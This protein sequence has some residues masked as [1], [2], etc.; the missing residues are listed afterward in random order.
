MFEYLSLPPIQRGLIA[1]LTAGVAFP[2]IGV[3]VIRM[4]L[5]TLR[6]M[7]MHGALLGSAI[8]MGIGI[9]PLAG[10]LVINIFL[11]MLLI[12]ITRGSEIPTGYVITFFM[13][14]S[15]ALAVIIIYK[16]RV[17]AKD[18]LSILWGNLYAVRP[19]ELI[20]NGLVSAAIILVV[21]LRRRQLTAVLF[22]AEVAATTGIAAERY[23]RFILLGTGITIAI[24]MRLV[25]ALLLDS[26]VLLPAVSSLL[27]AG[28]TGS[29]FLFSS[30]IGLV[31]ALIGFMLSLLLDIP[32]SGGVT[33]TSALIFGILLLRNSIRRRT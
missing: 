22:H 9:S 33:L 25:G 1:L 7:L 20:V 2:L 10:S 28:S 32:V 26:L 12:M 30:L 24:S 15:I 13:V 31:S 23:R 21:I 17:P 8:A 6:F 4:N 11:I 3:F 5:I 16:A 18:A 14:V 19:A 29:M 27:I